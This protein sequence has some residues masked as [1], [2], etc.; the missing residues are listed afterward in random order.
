M[1]K[2]RYWRSFPRT[3]QMILLFLMMFTFSQFVIFIWGMGLASGEGAALEELMDT[4]DNL[5]ERVLFLRLALTASQ[6]LGFFLIPALVFAYL[7]HPRP[8]QYLGLAARPKPLHI[9]VVTGIILGF[10][11]IIQTVGGWF[12]RFDF[13][14]FF[15][16]QLR[17]REALL[18]QF[19]TMNQY[20]GLFAVI[21]TLAVLPAIGEELL[22]RGILMRSF[23]AGTRHAGLSI[24]LSAMIFAFFH[25]DPYG[26]I[27]IFAAG[28]LLGWIY[29]ITGSLWMSILAHFLNNGI[30]V[31][32]MYAAK[33]NP[34]WEA[35]LDQEAYTIFIPLVGLLIFVL[36]INLLSKK[37]RPLP[38]DWS[39]DFKGGQ[40]D[41]GGRRNGPGDLI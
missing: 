33:R 21:L 11:P 4:P 7:A 6:T 34:A 18:D 16:E 9:G 41:Q 31:V 37:A 13:G 10:I 1:F 32:V 5:S 2:S 26:L 29:L 40:G 8:M 36:G 27:A 38:A 15:A 24:A 20:G 22:F 39:D 17:A 14:P 30:Q 3:L 35:Y 25:F 28:I 23:H 19:M 12:R